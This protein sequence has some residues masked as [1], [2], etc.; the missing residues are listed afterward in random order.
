M[1]TG[2]QTYQKDLIRD[3]YNDF[4]N[5]KDFVRFGWAES[6]LI[7]ALIDQTGLH[8]GAKI[9]DIGCGTGKYT[10]LLTQQG[11]KAV[12]IDL[13]ER[14]IELAQ[15]RFPDSTFQVGDVMELSYEPGSWD[16]ILCSGLSL[17]NEP[18]LS[19]LRPFMQQIIRFLKN[20]GWFIFSK[21]T[22]MTN[23]LSL[24]R[25]RMEHDLETFVRFFNTCDLVKVEQTAAVYPHLIIPL[26]RRVFDAPFPIAISKAINRVTRIPLRVYILLKRNGPTASGI[27]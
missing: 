24:R 26:G 6:A 5:R 2:F 16:A 11:M 15:K 20:G 25:T 19:V 18:D 4:Y 10:H 8:K 12:G 17:F 1:D 27:E 3:R 21:T 23:R 22:A 7:K 14:A 13:S 9:L